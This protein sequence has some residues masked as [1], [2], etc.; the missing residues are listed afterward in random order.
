MTFGQRVGAWA[1]VHVNASVHH[2]Q[3]LY[4][5]SVA[6]LADRSDPSGL[7]Y[8]LAGPSTCAL[9]ACRA[10]GDGGGLDDPE[11]HDQEIT[12]SYV[13]EIGT[14]V[15]NVQIVGGRHHA[16]ETFTPFGWATDQLP[17][18]PIETF[19][20]GD[21]PI[22]NGPPYGVHVI[23]CSGDAVVQPDGSWRGPTCQGGQADGGVQAFD[24]T[25]TFR[26]DSRGLIRCFAGASQRHVIAVV[27]AAKIDAD[28][29]A[30]GLLQ[31]SVPLKP[32][33]IEELLPLEEHEGG[34]TD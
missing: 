16:L 15:A 30:K 3:A 24:T 5:E 23:V 13:Q 7:H 21:I 26:Q 6:P 11:C 33:P 2:N 28:L 18:A 27:R 10:L 1:R 31:D 29:A 12:R 17:H 22:I 14:A 9:Y 4:L 19:L 32:L 8:F 34:S 20:E 25:W